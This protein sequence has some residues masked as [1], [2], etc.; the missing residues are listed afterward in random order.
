MA[1]QSQLTTMVR[2]LIGDINTTEVFTDDQITKAVVVGGLISAREFSFANDYTFDLDA[3]D[4]SPDP[5]ESATLDSNAMALFSLKAACMLNMSAYQKAINAG[6][7][8][9]DGDSEIDTT[10]GFKGYKDV[11]ELGPCKS[12]DKLLKQLQFNANVGRA[13][14]TPASI[15]TADNW[16][17]NSVY[18]FF[19]HF[20]W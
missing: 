8:V 9:R 12:Y 14:M 7:K 18:D 3:L 4:I 10:G 6:I 17:R 13:V 1:W 2:V 15:T 5:T 16:G 11:L 20:R 19:D